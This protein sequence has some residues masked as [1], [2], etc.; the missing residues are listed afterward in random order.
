[1]I[2]SELS[3]YIKENNLH[4]KDIN[5]IK[6]YLVM[7]LVKNYQTIE[8]YAIEHNIG[9][10]SVWAQIRLDQHKYIILDKA[11]FVKIKKVDTSGTKK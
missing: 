2:G 7:D 5:E 6:R 4:D 10:M 8:D 1:M 3:D 9:A 11:C